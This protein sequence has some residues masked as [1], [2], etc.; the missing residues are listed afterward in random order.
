M[1]RD[2]R[3]PADDAPL[4]ALDRARCYR[5]IA[6]ALGWSPARI[7]ALCRVP[8]RT[9]LLG[10]RAA[11]DDPPGPSRPEGPPK[12]PGRLTAKELAY[13]VE[14]YGDDPMVRRWLVEAG[15]VRAPL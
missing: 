2:D 15:L 7:A 8:V 1:S 9:V 14:T 5:E 13:V 12:A 11:A 10:L 6:Q 4:L 3:P